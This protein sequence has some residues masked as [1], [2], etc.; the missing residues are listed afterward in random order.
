MQVLQKADFTV[1]HFMIFFVY[2]AKC[3]LLLVSACK[4]SR[5]SVSGVLMVYFLRVVAPDILREK[6]TAMEK[7]HSAWWLYV[8]RERKGS[9][10]ECDCTVWVRNEN[11]KE[12]EEKSLGSGEGT[13][14]EFL[15]LYFPYY[16][17][18]RSSVICWVSLS[19]AVG[20]QSCKKPALLNM[21]HKSIHLK[22]TFSLWPYAVTDC[23]NTVRLT[24]DLITG[25]MLDDT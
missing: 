22:E 14:V 25:I 1:Y 12:S 9:V 10:K 24:I 13:Q 16:S 23:R 11:Q 15:S 6:C 4:P 3:H 17:C 18:V 2:H 19:R 8:L 21:S 20:K 5:G 7:R